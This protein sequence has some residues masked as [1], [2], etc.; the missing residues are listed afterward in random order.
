MVSGERVRQARELQGLTQA[1]LAERIGKDQSTVARIEIDGLQPSDEV[2]EAIAIQTGFPPSFFRRKPRAG[3]PAG[4]LQFRARKMSAGERTRVYQ[5]ARTVWESVQDM[6]DEISEIPVKLPSL[7]EPPEVAA[8]VTRSELGLQPD[9]PIPHLINAVERAGV[10][11]L[12]VPLP[13]KKWDAFCSWAGE[14][15]KRPVIVIASEAPGDRLR[16]SVAHEV[17]HLVLHRSLQ[18]ELKTIDQEANRFAAALLMPKSAI[19]Q[20]IVP[21]V[22][23]TSLADLKPRWGVSIQSLIYRARDLGIITDRQFRYLF[24]QLSKRGWRKQEPLDLPVERPRAVRKMA[25]ILYGDPIDHRQLAARANFRP[26]FAKDILE[27]HASREEIL[28][29]RKRQQPSTGKVH[30]LASRR[31]SLG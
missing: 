11:V 19:L 21:P 18:G 16:Y 31:N 23:L 10:I 5:Y 3:F 2:L 15:K 13:L 30:H 4:S 12:T 9:V 26:Q 6:A 22:T 25:E 17:G 24:E 28:A 8:D 1:E 14:E 7:D 27:L 20:E 29:G